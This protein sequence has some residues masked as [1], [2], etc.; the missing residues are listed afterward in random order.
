MADHDALNAMPI[1]EL[2]IVY[3]L[4]SEGHPTHGVSHKGQ[5]DKMILLGMLEMAKVTIMSPEWDEEDGE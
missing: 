4:D 3:S 2:T 1:A 5:E